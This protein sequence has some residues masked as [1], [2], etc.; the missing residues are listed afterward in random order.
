MPSLSS[1][2]LLRTLA[3]TG[4]VVV[5]AGAGF[6]LTNGQTTSSGSSGSGQPAAAPRPSLSNV[7]AAQRSAGQV[8]THVN[9]RLNGKIVTTN[10]I[11]SQTNFTKAALGTQ[12][13]RVVA[14]SSVPEGFAGAQHTTVPTPAKLSIGGVSLSKLE[15]CLNRV[16]AGRKVLL[17]N[18]A[19][20]LGNPAT[21]IVLEPLTAAH[22]FDVT[23]VGL[24]CSASSSDVISRTTVPAS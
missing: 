9:Y 14:S 22:I 5:V 2:L 15:G 10:A 4:A 12:V 17:A 6:L 7:H 20:Y 13:R 16:A 23:I 21:I 8:P 18:I 19:R 3:A 11:A 24:S 1:P